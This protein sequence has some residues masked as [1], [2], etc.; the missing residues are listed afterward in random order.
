MMVF[1]AFFGLSAI[2]L[3]NPSSKAAI[4]ASFAR[5]GTA[6]SHVNRNHHVTSSARERDSHLVRGRSRQREFRE[7]MG[8]WKAPE[9]WRRAPPCSRSDRALR[10]R[11]ISRI[12]DVKFVTRAA[13]TNIS[14][15]SDSLGQRNLPRE[16]RGGPFAVRGS[17]AGAFRPSAPKL[18]M[19]DRTARVPPLPPIGSKSRNQASQH[20][21]KEAYLTSRKFGR[22]ADLGFYRF[23]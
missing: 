10:V 12:L 7:L 8:T 3:A 4:I 6:I 19:P 22:R 9:A 21:R 11:R 23:R 20:V 18:T 13:A 14:E 17:R 15:V 16:Y 1:D 2:A 5:C